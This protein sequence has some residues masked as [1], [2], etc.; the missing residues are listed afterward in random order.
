MAFRTWPEFSKQ[1]EANVSTHRHTKRDGA[2]SRASR[3]A[4]LPLSRDECAAGC[5]PK[6]GQRE[7]KY[8][9]LSVNGNASEIVP[10]IFCDSFHPLRMMKASSRLI[11]APPWFSFYLEYIWRKFEDDRIQRT[12]AKNVAGP[13]DSDSHQSGVH[14][15]SREGSQASQIKEPTEE[16]RH[17]TDRDHL[18]SGC[19][20]KHT[21]LSRSREV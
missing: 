16:V 13:R 9:V 17:E 11:G 8:G 5:P 19:N 1:I 7:A 20:A 15:E 3:T 12:Q 18:A 14:A 21:R 6:A 4:W 2:I 10:A